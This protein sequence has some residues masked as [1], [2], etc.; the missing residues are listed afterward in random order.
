MFDIHAPIKKRYIRANQ[1]P[2]MNKTLQKRVMTRSR[3]RNKFVKYKTQSNETAYKKQRNYC[4]NLF[5]KEKNFFENV[6]TKN[7]TDNKFFWK[8]VKPF[9]ANQSTSNRN[10]ITLTQNDL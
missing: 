4:V 8:T 1:G 2:F 3:L 7:I 9:L 6:D 10:K 5:R